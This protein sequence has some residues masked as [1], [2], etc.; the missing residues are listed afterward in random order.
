MNI[1]KLNCWDFFT[2]DFIP[3]EKTSL[4]LSILHIYLQYM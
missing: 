2:T 1:E 4:H 3:D